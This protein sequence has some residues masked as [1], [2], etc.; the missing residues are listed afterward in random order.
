MSKTAN[1]IDIILETVKTSPQVQIEVC[2]PLQSCVR[3][4][5]QLTKGP[6]NPQLASSAYH[7]GR[8]GGSETLLQ[9]K[10]CLY[11]PRSV[12]GRKGLELVPINSQNQLKLPCQPELTPGNSLQIEQWWNPHGQRKGKLGKMKTQEFLLSSLTSSLKIGKRGHL[13]KTYSSCPVVFI[14]QVCV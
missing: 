8:A 5:A 2:Q 4:C 13:L 14:S 11:V 6:E 1:P 7:K 3:M 10:K 9:A 12:Q